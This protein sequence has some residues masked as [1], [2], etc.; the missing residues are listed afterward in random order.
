VSDGTP[1]IDWSK[2]NLVF[3]ADLDVCTVAGIVG[4]RLE[5]DLAER[6][7]ESLGVSFHGSDATGG[8][9]R[10]GENLVDP[11]GILSAKQ[12]AKAQAERPA[13]PTTVH[14]HSTGAADA[15]VAA[16]AGSPFRLHSR[17]PHPSARTQ[18]EDATWRRLLLE[19]RAQG[20]EVEL[21]CPAAPVQ[22]EGRVPTGEA[23]YYR[24]RHNTC[25]LELGVTDESQDWEG[26][27]DVDGE[28]T[29]SHLDPDQA[30]RSLLHL[31]AQWCAETS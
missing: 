29:A 4:E 5:I 16:L 31:H 25:S 24:C 11:F 27:L 17:N 19:L 18:L 8:T 30:V 7:H 12:L 26:E 20:W 14:V 3:G 1:P 9:V 21:T 28:F 22:L 15:I 10:V 2:Q 23:F 6:G 13:E